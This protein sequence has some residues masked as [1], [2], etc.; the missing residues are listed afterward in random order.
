MST[1][2]FTKPVREPGYL[3]ELTEKPFCETR[4]FAT[5]HARFRGFIHTYETLV[6]L[7]DILPR[8]DKNRAKEMSYER[9][10]TPRRCSAML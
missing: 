3:A 5:P 7:P 10:Q 2:Q 9:S 8:N 1:H 4:L 6:F